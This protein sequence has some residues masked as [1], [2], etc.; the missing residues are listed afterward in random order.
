MTD[1]EFRLSMGLRVRVNYA[2]YS[3]ELQ[4]TELCACVWTCTW[5][6]QS[7]PYPLKA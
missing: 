7:R 3:F 6:V 5:L 2:D 1:D 4:N